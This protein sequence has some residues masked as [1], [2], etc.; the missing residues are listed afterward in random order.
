MFLQKKVTIKTMKILISTPLYPP[1]TAR[2]SIFAKQL[3]MNLQMIYVEK[4]LITLLAYSDFPENINNVKIISVSKKQNLLKRIIL[5]TKILLREVKNNGIILLNQAGISSL[6]TLL[7]AK[8]FN[9]KTISFIMENEV[10]ERSVQF[11]MNKKSLKVWQINFIQY[12]V[13][14][15]SS[16]VI[17]DNL[18]LKDTFKKKYNLNENNLI[19]QKFPIK[20]F[21]SPFS[22]VESKEKEKLEVIKEWKFFVEFLTKTIS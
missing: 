14:K 10:E 8:L 1:E 13:S 9:K 4:H 21:F 16:V 20:N 11:N 15:W 7:V 6:L 22:N 3:A 2:V 19:V 18:K 17:F 5:F 12:L